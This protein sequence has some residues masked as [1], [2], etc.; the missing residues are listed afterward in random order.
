MDNHEMLKYM[1]NQPE[2]GEDSFIGLQK[3]VATLKAT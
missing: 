2:K 1:Q 3:F